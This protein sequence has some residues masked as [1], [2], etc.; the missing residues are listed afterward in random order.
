[1]AGRRLNQMTRMI[2]VRHGESLGNLNRRFY[3]HTDGELTDRGRAQARM[4]AEHLR[5][6]H[7]DTAYA[8]DLKRAYETGK[9]VAEPHGL[10]PIPDTELREIYAGDWE[11]LVFEEI[12]EKYPKGFQEWITDIGSSRPDGGESVAELYERINKEVW[13]I[14]EENEGKT[15]LIAIHATPIRVLACYWMGE[16]VKGAQKLGWVPNA[17]V[18]IVDYDTRSHTV[19]VK[20]IGDASFMGDMVTELPKNV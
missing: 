8:S 1:M 10:T 4:T 13:R 6:T 15:V 5:N 11:N 16:D 7:I 3:G 20:V 18:S 9:I 2:F 14:A 12:A 17:S 19:N